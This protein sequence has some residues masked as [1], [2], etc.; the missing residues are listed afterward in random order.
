MPAMKLKSEEIRNMTPGEREDKL[1][2]LRK[3]LLHER[4]VAAMGGAPPNTGRIRSLRS[5]I[6][7]I[8]TI[9]TEMKR[10]EA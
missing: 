9:M 1:N 4:G 7:R 3:E 6:S 8:I 10:G 5:H 2:E